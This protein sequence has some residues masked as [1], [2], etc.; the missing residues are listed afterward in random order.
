MSHANKMIFFL[1]IPTLKINLNLLKHDNNKV[2]TLSS[3]LEILPR[4]SSALDEIQPDKSLSHAFLSL[5]L[6]NY[7]L[8]LHLVTSLVT[9]LRRKSY[10][11]LYIGAR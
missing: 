2:S 7:N 9:R 8:V 4:V 5:H 3:V 11:S 10:D 1:K 6:R